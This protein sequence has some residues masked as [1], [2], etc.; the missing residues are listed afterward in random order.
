MIFEKCIQLA[1]WAPASTK[2]NENEPL[3]NNCHESTEKLY[4]GLLT[5]LVSQDTYNI[6]SCVWICHY[7]WAIPLKVN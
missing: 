4:T 5:N 1:P 3:L 2:R 6:M 7:L